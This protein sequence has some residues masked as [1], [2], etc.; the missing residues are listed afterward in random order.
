MPRA[1][2]PSTPSRD[3]AAFAGSRDRHAGAALSPEIA[4]FCQ[5]GISIVVA[6]CGGGDPVASL[7]LACSID[8]EGRVRILLQRPGNEEM[9][10]AL[11]AGSRIA[12]TFSR[13]VDHRS[14][15]LK[16]S[17]AR[18]VPIQAGDEEL[19]ATQ[20][21]GMGRELVDVGYSHAFAAGYCAFF[22]A[23]IVAVRFMPE[24]VFVQTPG[25]G[26]GSRLAP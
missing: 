18:L 14:I 3:I 24:Q 8:D 6:A 7:A 23:D 4:E 16:G 13:P 19:L 15:Q 9:L 22:F 12:A 26:A 20:C 17:G 5:S 2:Q 10:G 21:A 25:P 11:D 1:S